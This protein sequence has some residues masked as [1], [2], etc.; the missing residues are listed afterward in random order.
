MS[1]D[2]DL[3][4][5]GVYLLTWRFTILGLSVLFSFISTAGFW[6]VVHL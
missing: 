2:L 1:W 4:F 3:S 5:H 6:A